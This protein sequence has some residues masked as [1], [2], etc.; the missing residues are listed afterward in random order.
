MRWGVELMGMIKHFEFTMVLNDDEC[1]AIAH[2]CGN[3][4]FMPSMA[5]E[6]AENEIISALE[7]I[8]EWDEEENG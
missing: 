7:A 6:F 5:D 4:M 2:A 1:S 3:D 8:C